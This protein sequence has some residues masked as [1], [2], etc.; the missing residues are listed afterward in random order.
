VVGTGEPSRVVRPVGV[1][2]VDEL[3]RAHLTLYSRELAHKLSARAAA[4]TVAHLS[5]NRAD[6]HRAAGLVVCAR[7]VIGLQR[8]DD[9]GVA[10][11][12]RRECGDQTRVDA[13]GEQVG[14]L[15]RGQQNASVAE[16]LAHRRRVDWQRTT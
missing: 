7:V 12:D 2:A 11:A 13:A 9:D 10:A 16:Q 6:V 14:S 1:P 5:V 4:P 8:G 15:Q 3:G